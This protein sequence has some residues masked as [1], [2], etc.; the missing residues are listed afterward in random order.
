MRRLNK[1]TSKDR[2]LLIVSHAYL[3][4]QV[5]PDKV[6]NSGLM[7]EWNGFWSC[8]R[9]SDER[10]CRHFLPALLVG[11]SS[12]PYAG[13]GIQIQRECVWLVNVRGIVVSLV[14]VFHKCSFM[15][16]RSVPR[17]LNPSKQLPG[18]ATYSDTEAGPLSPS[19]GLITSV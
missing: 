3:K 11:M 9:R 16:W 7:H 1:G 10:P 4:I 13:G 2:T 6:L 19:A 5:A 8:W 18:H 14:A 15:T 17:T 12:V